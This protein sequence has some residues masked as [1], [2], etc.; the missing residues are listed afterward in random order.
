[1]TELVLRRLLPLAHE[2]LERYGVDPHARDRLIEIIE[3][4]CV[5]EANGAS[6]QSRQFR[7]LYDGGGLDRVEALREM[8]VRYRDHITERAGAHVAGRLVARCDRRSVVPAV[9]A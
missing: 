6:W 7:A 3:R 8:T 4:R 9:A 1:M 2:G 5:E